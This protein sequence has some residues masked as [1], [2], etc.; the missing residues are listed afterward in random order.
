MP[1]GQSSPS[2]PPPAPAERAGPTRERVFDAVK[3]VAAVSL[4]LFS[5]YSAIFGVFQDMVQKG[6]HLALVLLMV[7]LASRRRRGADSA[8][9]RPIADLCLMAGA[10]GVV[11]YH[12]VFYEAVANRWGELAEWEYWLAIGC[13]AVLL[14]ATRRTIGWAIVIL[15]LVFLLYA[16]LGPYLP[17]MLAH[18]GYSLERVLS[19]LYLGGGGI[20][21]TPLGVSATFVI[22]IIIYGAFLEHSG[23]GR[24][25]MDVATGTTGRSRGGPAKASVVGSSLM[26][27]ISGTAVANVL[28]TGT[29]SIPLMKRN[30]YKAHVAGAVEAVASTGGQLMPPVMGAAAFIMADMIERPYLDIA[31]A[32]IIPAVLYYVVLFTVVHLEAVKRGIPVLDRAE[33]PGVAG[34]LR[35]GGHLLLS[36]PVFVYLLLIGYSV[37]Y[38]AFWAVVVTI[39]TSFLRRSSRLSPRRFV[40][41]MVSS[42]EAVIP[43]A[44]ACATAG[45]IIGVISLTGLGLKFSTLVVTVSGGNLLAALVLTMVASLILGMGLPTAAAYI[46]VATLVAPA[47]VEMGVDLLAAHL[48]VFYGAMLSSITPPVALAAYAAAGLADANPMRIALTAVSFGAAAFVVPLFF[49]YDTALIGAGSAPEIG[50][51]VGTGIAG[52]LCIAATIQ[53]WALVRTR[54]FERGAFG[55]AAVCLIFPSPQADLAGIGLALAVLIPQYLRWRRAGHA[56]RTGE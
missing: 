35:T 27:M 10:F 26:G 53:G 50:I 15:A 37:M 29:I 19:Q 33:L 30:G 7:F 25:L 14:E 16:L 5:L 55:V 48:F 9:W 49:V 28:T 20:F 4:A 21:G 44:V 38:A 40:A 3:A 13:I 6:T 8:G 47:L 41:A 36:L 34:T 23:A 52:A 2:M 56:P 46:L 11:F 17:G 45:I 18:R 39:G 22:L 43:V 42:V 1:T 12:V 24:V 51:A 54:W 32:A 31:R